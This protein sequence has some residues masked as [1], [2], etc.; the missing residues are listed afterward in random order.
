MRNKG[1]QL[2]RP[3]SKSSSAVEATDLARP[4]IQRCQ[5]L[6]TSEGLAIWLEFLGVYTW[7]SIPSVYACACLII[8]LLISYG[9][10]TS[11]WRLWKEKIL[12][13]CCTCLCISSLFTAGRSNV[14]CS[15]KRLHF[16]LSTPTAFR[17]H[18]VVLIGWGWEEWGGLTC[19]AVQLCCMCNSRRKIWGD[20][21]LKCES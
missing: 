16:S 18:W 4:L 1:F 8:A 20:S 11:S 3:N 13:L 2:Q 6:S 5:L 19:V 10:V 21:P 14:Y 15:L 7:L 17:F 12:F 9:N